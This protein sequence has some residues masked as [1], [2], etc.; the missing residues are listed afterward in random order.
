MSDRLEM[1]LELEQVFRHIL[2]DLRRDLAE[3]WGDRINGA[4]FGVL[5]QLEQKSPQI[6]TALAQEF[7]VS[8][9]HITHVADQ[10][11]KKNLAYR[12]RSKL[13]KRV[14]ELHISELGKKTIEELSY[15]K[16]EYFRRKFEK[17]TTEEIETLL[18]LLQKI[19]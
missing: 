13:D 19:S 7:N 8:V 15:K 9:S 14:V 3:I 11:E 18:T 10:L 16:S 4:E 12:K 17:L 1:S 6:V 2:R 5:K